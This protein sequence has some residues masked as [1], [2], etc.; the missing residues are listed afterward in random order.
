MASFDPPS[1]ALLQPDDGSI[2]M[3]VGILEILVCFY[4]GYVKIQFTFRGA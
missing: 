1:R 2:T 3:L 4:L